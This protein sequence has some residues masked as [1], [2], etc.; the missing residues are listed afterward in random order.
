MVGEP[1]HYLNRPADSQGSV[2]KLIRAFHDRVGA[3]AAEGTS[4]SRLG[5]Q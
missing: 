2:L 3:S 1:G 4:L 5:P